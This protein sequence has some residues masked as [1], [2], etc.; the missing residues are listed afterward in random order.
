MFY[1]TAMTAEELLY[2]LA[3]QK[4][5]GV[6]DIIAKRL[7]QHCGSAKQ[8]F[9]E[10][11]I[12]LARIEGIGRKIIH[13]LQ[14]KASLEKAE[15]E[16]KYIE[17]QKIKPLTY[18]S[19]NYPDKLKHCV[20]APLVLFLSGNINLNNSKL[21]SIVGT[22]KITNY[23]IESCR[24]LIED[25]APFDPLIV[26]GFA[27][28]VDIVAHQIAM[29]LGLQTIG[30]LAQGMNHIYPK[31]HKKY[32]VK[33]E[34]HGGFITEFWSNTFPDKENF[35][36]RNRIVAGMTEATVVIESAERGGSLITA[37]MAYDYNREVF[38]VPGKTSDYYSQ[39]CNN[40]IK[41]QKANMLTSAADLVYVLNW[42][43]NKALQPIQKSLFVDLNHNEQII[44]DYLNQNGKTL[45]DSIAFEC[46]M[47]IFKLS[48]LLIEMEIKGLIR[49]LPGKLF[50]I[51]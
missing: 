31:P 16:L 44:Y 36:K 19:E 1:N 40:L 33:M 32:M 7:I 29:E 23:G 28:G 10:K 30:V 18:F 43:I 39:G 46:N 4:T 42:D 50:E 20:D 35:V 5:E 11:A 49:P 45:L 37:N 6:G 25:I 22:R 51:I 41:T 48:S 14:D 34:E 27:Y 13:A 17:N 26:S 3:L 24:K 21:I 47:P 9:E 12:A 2:T 8:V 38:A 15:I